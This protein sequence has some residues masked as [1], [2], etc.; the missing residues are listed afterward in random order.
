MSKDKVVKQEKWKKLLVLERLKGVIGYY[1]HAQ[2]GRRRMPDWLRE[3]MSHSQS[4]SLDEFSNELLDR[5]NQINSFSGVLD[6]TG[7]HIAGYDANG[8]IPLP[9][10]YHVWNHDGVNKNYK[11]SGNGFRKSQ[12]F[13]DRD[14]AGFFPDRLDELFEDRWSIVYRNGALKPYLELA[15]SLYNFNIDLWRKHLLQQSKS[16]TD[17]AWHYRFQL[18][19]VKLMYRYLIR[20]PLPPI[21][22]RIDVITI[23]PNGQIKFL[24]NQPTRNNAG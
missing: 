1:G 15:D 21:G 20:S 23:E 19:T 9:C 14:A 5:L 13:R 18:E 8:S 10:F 3:F 22:R 17:W 12:D 7:F 2:I 4:S 24:Q 16:L 6:G 11:V